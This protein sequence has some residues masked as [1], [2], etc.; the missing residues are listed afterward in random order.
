MDRYS[1]WGLLVL[2]LIDG[3]AVRLRYGAMGGATV[4]LDHIAEVIVAQLR[5]PRAQEGIK[6]DSVTGEAWLSVGGRTD[7]TLRLGRPTS[8]EGILGKLGEATTIHLAVDEPERFAQALRTG[9]PGK[10]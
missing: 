9:P 6:V 2:A 5:A 1:K 4:T 7:V 8:V 3:P 10:T